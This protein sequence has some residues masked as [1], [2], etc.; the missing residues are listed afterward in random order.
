MSN[1]NVEEVAKTLVSMF[2]VAGPEIA[3]YVFQIQRLLLDGNPISPEQLASSLQISQDV[4]A[5]LLSYPGAEEVVELDE[6]GNIAGLGVTLIPKPHRYEV[7]QH[8]FY[9]LC[10]TEALVFPLIHGHTA[11]IES[12]DPVTGDKVHLTVTPEGIER[13]EPTTAVVSSMGSVPGRDCVYGRFFTSRETASK[14]LSEHPG[15]AILS[16]DEV[17]QVWKLVS[18]KEPL[19][20]IFPT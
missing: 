16:L 3:H 11:V 6:E 13:V 14:W 7:N 15:A 2:Q 9:V 20:S 8:I 19:K 18:E 12:P 4:V 5:A 17:Y 1:P 10:A